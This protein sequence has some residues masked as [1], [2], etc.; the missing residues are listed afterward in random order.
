MA[1]E[2]RDY[3]S[4]LGFTAPQVKINDIRH[5]QVYTATHDGA[6]KRL[7]Y[8][9][10]AFISFSYGG[11]NIE[12]YN[13][14]AITE[15]NS[16]QRKLYAEFDD[17][18]SKNDVINGQFYWGSKFNANNLEFTLFTDG[19]T[20]K[21]LNDFKYWFKPGVYRELILAENPN[22]VLDARISEPPEYHMLP[23]EEKVAFKVAGTDVQTSTTSY[24]GRIDIKFVADEPFWRAKIQVLDHYENNNWTGG[25]W[26][27]ANGDLKDVF[28]SEDALKMIYEDGIPIGYM[29]Q[30]VNSENDSTVSSD[31][32]IFLGADKIIGY[33]T[34]QDADGSYLGTAT[35][36][37]GVVAYRVINANSAAVSSLPAGRQSAKHFYYPGT[38]PSYPIIR[39]TLSPTFYLD[40]LYMQYPYNYISERLIPDGYNTITL[41]SINKAELRF[42]APSY[43]IAYNRALFLLRTGTSQ[44]RSVEELRQRIREEVHH[45]IVRDWAIRCLDNVTN[46]NNVSSVAPTL[47]SLLAATSSS[48]FPA[49]F[50]VNCK[51]GQVKGTFHYWPNFSQRGIGEPAT[52]EEDCGNMIRGVLPA[53]TDRNYPAEDGYIHKYET[54]HPEYSHLIYHDYNG[55]LQ[56]FS[57]TYQ[58]LYL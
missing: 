16:M 38:A 45:H 28:S 1:I 3:G 39:F 57:I 7:P 49:T 26:K 51:T 48:F 30:N 6:G 2:Y 29:L 43:W 32:A 23:F 53:I 5:T 42:S 11:K 58:Y 47:Q 4:V 20:E 33:D 10:R 9:N 21:Q 46:L 44:N 13:L 36:G 17:E 8:M 27:D 31:N 37:H 22:R 34:V 15:N 18:V 25:M 19:I 56:N 50:E 40:T 14:I 12:D 35:V 41:E 24:K 55:G 52:F 54:K